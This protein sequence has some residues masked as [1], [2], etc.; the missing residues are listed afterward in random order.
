MLSM[1]AQQEFQKHCVK[2][3]FFV[4][5]NNLDCTNDQ[6]G[7]SLLMIK[8]N[9]TLTHDIYMYHFSLNKDRLL[10]YTVVHIFLLRANA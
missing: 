8:F 6:S 9:Q 5:A 2:I 4:M 10:N 1:Q 3:H 7:I